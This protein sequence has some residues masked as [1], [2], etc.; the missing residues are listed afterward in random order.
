MPSTPI[1]IIQETPSSQETVTIISPENYF[2]A[3][4]IEQTGGQNTF[5]FSIPAT[6]E[7]TSSIEEGMIAGF[8]DIDNVYQFFEIKRITEFHGDIMTRRFYCEHQ[9]FELLDEQITWKRINNSTLQQ[10]IAGILNPTGTEDAESRWEIGNIIA[11]GTISSITFRLINKLSAIQETLSAFA[12]ANGGTP[13][14]ME[15]R[16]T[17]DSTGVT[18]RYIDVVS[19]RGTNRGKR[20]EYSKDITSI[21]REIDTTAVKTAMYG[22]GASVETPSGETQLLRFKDIVWSTGGG[23]PA[24]KPLG[25][26]YIVNT[27]ALSRFGHMDYNATPG[28][29]L[30]NRFGF[31]NNQDIIDENELLQATWD[32]L[33]SVSTPIIQYTIRAIDL[34]EIAGLDYEKVRIGDTV[35]VVDGAFIPPLTVQVRVIEIDRNLNEPEK[36]AFVFGNFIPLSVDQGSTIQST[37]DVINQ[38]KG[39]WEGGSYDLNM[40]ADPAF[41]F[42]KPSGVGVSN[43][44]YID[45]A[46][47][48][49]SEALP[50]QWWQWEDIY[51]SQIYS[52]ASLQRA[53]LLFGSQA[54]VIQRNPPSRPYQYIRLN[55]PTGLNGP[56]YASAY[57]SAYERTT[58]DTIATM[59]VWA[60]NS[61]YAR[62]GANPLNTFEVQ[63][64]T[65][66][67]YEWKRFGGLVNQGDALP[68]GTVYLEITFFN[69]AGSNNTTKHLISGVQM[70]N[71]DTNSQFIYETA[72]SKSMCSGNRALCPTDWLIYKNLRVTSGQA[73]NGPARIYLDAN[74][75]YSPDASAIPEILVRFKNATYYGKIT[76]DYTN[77][78]MT[79]AS[80]N[81]LEFR[82]GEGILPGDNRMISMR[83]NGTMSLVAVICNNVNRRMEFD[84]AGLNGGVGEET[85]R[86]ALDLH[87]FIGTTSY[88]YYRAYA[89]AFLTVSERSAKKN[90]QDADCAD[91]YNRIKALKMKKFHY[92]DESEKANK[93]I[94]IIADDLP[95][96]ELTDEGKHNVSLNALIGHLIGANQVLM[97]KVEALEKQIAKPATE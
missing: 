94:G 55:I 27:D 85:L 73:F 39:R 12:N 86:P 54:A 43:T 2:N 80:N 48:A 1:Y 64:R 16:M 74:T 11:L 28:N 88:R 83:E 89:G 41:E 34:E 32:Y 81:G 56:Y 95:D 53:E 70:V 36:N 62:I 46:L 47:P 21:Q 66:Q 84:N 31:Y 9:I 51:N 4:H 61:S 58:A 14:E 22:F 23:D 40:V 17:Y 93:H 72:F 50:Y 78:D 33:V 45:D 6:D 15:F 18:H 76:M 92:K 57:A 82:V 35:A 3:V 37:A 42:L 91:S 44:Y 26:E 29:Q 90:E 65:G 71:K 60:I 79:F 5:D 77:N 96:E 87:G 49:F 75:D 67:N 7:W 59:M 13:P 30:K 10:I 24:D 8:L 68:I 69:A 52:T 20:F 63:L 97:A 25:Q 19:A 38:N